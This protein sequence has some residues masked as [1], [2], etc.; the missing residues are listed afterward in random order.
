MEPARRC[1]WAYL[2]ALE[3]KRPAS[4][5]DHMRSLS[6]GQEQGSNDV[7]NHS[8]VSDFRRA[9]PTFGK[10]RGML[11]IHPYVVDSNVL[12]NDLMSA[13]R[14]GRPGALVASARVGS[15]RYYASAHVFDEVP[16]RMAHQ[17]R[18]AKVDPA[19]AYQRWVSEYL[20]AI[21]FV[22]M[23]AELPDDSRAGRVVA[24]DPDDAA[25]AALV[26]L[27]GPISLSEDG[28]L[29]DP[30]LATREWLP[31]TRAGRTVAES[32]QLPVGST[33][34]SPRHRCDREECAD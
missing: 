27:L 28:H 22:T 14:R 19:I 21:L 24:R 18:K 32:D 30:G 1:A 2:K 10:S 26:L 23:P 4:L 13:V 31:L 33:W 16:E 6:D 7:A 11:S 25:T 3:G 12:L 20:Q 9:N 29:V 5:H 34:G 8:F 15:C 17:A